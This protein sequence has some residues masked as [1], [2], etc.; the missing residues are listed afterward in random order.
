MKTITVTMS[1]DEYNKM[2]KRDTTARDIIENNSVLMRVFFARYP[3]LS[4]E[5]SC[6]VQT[7]NDAI[8]NAIDIVI[9]QKKEEVIVLTKAVREKD[10]VIQTLKKRIEVLESDAARSFWK[11]IFKKRG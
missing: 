10:K 2:R 4:L 5:E 1:K 8:K 6:T 11:R 3:Y 7:K 9:D